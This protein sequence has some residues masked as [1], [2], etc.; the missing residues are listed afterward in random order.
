MFLLVR[1]C[2]EPDHGQGVQFTQSEK[3]GPNIGIF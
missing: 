2:K 3:A 1:A